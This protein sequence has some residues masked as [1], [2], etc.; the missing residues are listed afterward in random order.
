MVR[1]LIAPGFW[2]C[3]NDVTTE[4]T[5]WVPDHIGGQRP[6]VEL[7]V[8]RCDVEYQEATDSSASALCSCSTF[9]VGICARCRV[10]VCGNHSRLIG[11][12]RLCLPHAEEADDAERTG[13]REAKTKQRDDA[14][15]ATSVGADY[16]RRWIE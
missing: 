5:T 15:Q 10:P 3:R 4:T 1:D 14:Q 9:A 7:H 6:M 11:T 12:A 2:R 8:Q 16:T 13:L